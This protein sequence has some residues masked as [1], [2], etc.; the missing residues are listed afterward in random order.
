VAIQRFLNYVYERTYVHGGA[1]ETPV[2]LTQSMYDR[3]GR[4]AA[5]FDDD[6]DSSGSTPA[7]DDKELGFDYD[8]AGNLTR[9]TYTTLPG[10]PVVPGL[11]K[12]KYD[13]AGRL[14]SITHY[15]GS[16]IEY[17]YGYDDASRIVTTTTVVG[18]DEVTEH[19]DYSYD[20]AGQVTSAAGTNS[21]TYA[22]DDN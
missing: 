8:L 13:K 4:L 6:V 17:G 2:G 1:V 5:S 7:I 21:N 15:V 19:E 18:G 3:L 11:I 22:Y 16:G 14:T 12:S 20:N 9:T 10:A